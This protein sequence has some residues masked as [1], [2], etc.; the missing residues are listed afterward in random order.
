[1]HGAFLISYSARRPHRS[2]EVREPGAP[3]SHKPRLLDRMARELRVRHFSPRTEEAYVQ[4]VRRFI[5]HHRKRHP[6]EMRA[7]EIQA[8]L[9]SLAVDRRVSASTP[10]QALSAILFLY[11]NVLRID[12]G[13]VEDVVRAKTS[14]RLPVVL[15]RDEVQEVL[16][17]LNGTTALMATLLYGGGLRLLECA[18][19]RVKDLDFTKNQ[20]VVRAGKGNRDRITILPASIGAALIQHLR[21]VRQQHAE[22]L[23]K[24]AGHVALPFALARKYPNASRDWIWQWVFPATRTYV[25]LETRERRRHHL[26]ESVLQRA[27]KL[28][29]AKAGITKPASCHSLRHSFATHLIEAGYDIRTVQELL[30][31]R[32]VRTTMVYTHVLNRG[33]YGV[34]SPADGLVL[35]PFPQ[36]GSEPE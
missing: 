2:T 26:H 13:T 28:A 32:D 33:G 25:D 23:R 11:R 10:N 15:T 34:R 29:V 17:K 16:R 7:P 8:F 18:Q 20:I 12:P 21:S 4:W 9:T 36:G 24:G 3:A 27:I 22:D 14:R 5:L 31:H 1:M 35:Q 6:A 19:L 30:G